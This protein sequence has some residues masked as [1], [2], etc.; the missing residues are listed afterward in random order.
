MT[1][2]PFYL[3]LLQDRSIRSHFLYSLYFHNCW[4]P[5]FGPTPTGACYQEQSNLVARGMVGGWKCRLT[6][7]YFY[8]TSV[9]VSQLTAS[10][11]D[12][13]YVI[14]YIH[15]QQ[16]LLLTYICLLQG[17]VTGLHD[18]EVCRPTYSLDFTPR[19]ST[20]KMLC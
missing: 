13:C 7:Q 20:C 18:S 17:T 9:V 16:D 8:F 4:N 14:F 15:N 10:F 2:W 6:I 5:N 3:K 1:N 11:R 12:F 19:H